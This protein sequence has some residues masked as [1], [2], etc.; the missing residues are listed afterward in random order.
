MPKITYVYYQL[1]SILSDK[2]ATFTI[3]IGKKWTFGHPSSK[4]N[5]TSKFLAK[6][7]KIIQNLANPWR[8]TSKI[9]VKSVLKPCKPLKNLSQP[10]I[11]LQNLAKTRRAQSKVKATSVAKPCKPLQNAAIP[12]NSSQILANPRNTLK[13]T[14]HG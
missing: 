5:V 3:T 11:T 13:S 7:W 6:S 4:C 10:W 8:A 9:Q 12:R 2:L 14:I 1:L